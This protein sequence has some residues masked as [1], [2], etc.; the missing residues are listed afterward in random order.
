MNQ[1]DATNIVVE[2]IMASKPGFSL[3]THSTQ[4]FEKC[5]AFYYQNDSYMKS[6]NIRDM[7][8]G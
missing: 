2:K 6:G 1:N 4:E 8:V 7:S 3:M 5:F